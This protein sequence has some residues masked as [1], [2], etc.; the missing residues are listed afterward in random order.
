MTFDFWY[1]SS[2][3]RNTAV[4]CNQ[5]NAAYTRTVL[6]TGQIDCPWYFPILLRFPSHLA[7]FQ[8]V[9]FLNF[10]VPSP[11]MNGSP[12]L[13]RLMYKQAIPFRI[14]TRGVV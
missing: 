5:S 13:S 1:D 3:R 8:P 2:A 11:V 9:W 10:R 7:F 12:V 6:G 14:K 4:S